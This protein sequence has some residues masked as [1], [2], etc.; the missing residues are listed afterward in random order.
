MA[1]VTGVSAK[2]LSSDN[3]EDVCYSDNPEF[4][5][6]ED[7][8]FLSVPSARTEVIRLLALFSPSMYIG[9]IFSFSKSNQ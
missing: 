4:I 8:Q 5:F 9:F 7:R 2:Y 3:I 1:R 6:Y